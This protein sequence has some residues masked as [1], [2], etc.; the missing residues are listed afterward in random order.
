VTLAQLIAQ[1]RTDADDVATPVL[2]SDAAVTGWLNEAV[3]EA[4]NRALLIHDV[5]TTAVCR[6]TVTAGVAVYPVHTS[7]INITRC[8]FTPT[9]DENTEYEMQGS[10][11][12]EQDKLQ[13]GWR[14]LEEVPSAFIHKDTSLRLNRLP[15][16]GVLDMEVNRLPLAAMVLTTDTPEIAARHH[17]HLVPWALFRA[18]SVPDSETLDPNRAALAEREFTKMFGIRPDATIQRA[19][20]TSLPHGN[21]SHW[22]G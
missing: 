22:L 8:A 3:D 12:Y 9:D 20:E 7:V 5:S 16:A 21:A 1:F 19:S 14:K 17:R 2:F 13:P 6:I 11:E 15:P 4:A 18:F 10:T